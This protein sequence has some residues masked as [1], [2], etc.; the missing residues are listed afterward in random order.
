MGWNTSTV[1]D[2]ELTFHDDAL[3]QT[4]IFNDE[5][6][7]YDPIDVDDNQ[8]IEV[9]IT[10]RLT[11]ETKLD[12]VKVKDLYEVD[13]K[14]GVYLFW[15]ER[16][17]QPINWLFDYVMKKDG[18]IKIIPCL[19]TKAYDQN[20]ETGDLYVK[21]PEYYLN[22][23]ILDDNVSL[24]LKPKLYKL[25]TVEEINFLSKYGFNYSTDSDRIAYFEMHG[26]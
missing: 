6:D 22:S 18:C 11:S 7:E 17:K 19:K 13:K 20:F 3:P 14:S 16:G 15:S 12:H 24:G 23:E 2:Y 1:G 25:T 4:E 9:T 8:L 10:N 21:V 26:E 5:T